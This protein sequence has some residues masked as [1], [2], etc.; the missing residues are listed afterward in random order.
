[1]ATEL[2]VFT[3]EDGLHVRHQ[4][5]L[6]GIIYATLS[7][8]TEINLDWRVPVQI[9]DRYHWVRLLDGGFVAAE[10]LSFINPAP[11]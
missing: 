9:V 4:P 2:S 1:M 8:G 5:G 11:K 7:R 3:T 6:S 10:Y